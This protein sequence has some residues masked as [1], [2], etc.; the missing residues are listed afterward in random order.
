MGVPLKIA[1]SLI[2]D[3]KDLPCNVAMVRQWKLAEYS[4]V[5][6]LAFKWLKYIQKIIG[7]GGRI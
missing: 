4:S 5:M 7:C 6:S 2:I 1:P 3:S